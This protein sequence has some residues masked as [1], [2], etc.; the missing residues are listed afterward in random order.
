MPFLTLRYPIIAIFAAETD[1]AAHSWRIS[2]ND[3]LKYNA[4][5]NDNITIADVTVL[6]NMMLGKE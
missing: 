6:M 5:C 3:L 2:E 1:D 4:N